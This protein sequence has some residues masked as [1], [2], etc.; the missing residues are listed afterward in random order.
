MK[1]RLGPPHLVKIRQ[2]YQ[3]LYM[4]TY[5]LMWLIAEL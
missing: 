2:Q 4:K 3:A 5:T 1:V